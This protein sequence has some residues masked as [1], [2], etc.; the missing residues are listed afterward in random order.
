MSDITKIK[1]DNEREHS[2]KDFPA[3]REFKKRAEDDNP[4]GSGWP[5]DLPLPTSGGYGYTED[6]TVHKIDKKYLPED[7]RWPSD[8]PLPTA[9]GYGYTDTEYGSPVFNEDVTTTKQNPDDAYAK[10]T[11]VLDTVFMGGDTYKV[12][13]DGFNYYPVCRV[14]GPNRGIGNR[15]ISTTNVPDTGEP[16]YIER[17]RNGR[18]TLYTKTAGTFNVTVYEPTKVDHKIDEKY[19]PASGGAMVVTVSTEDFETYEADKTFDEISSAVENG[20]VVRLVMPINGIYANLS[21]FKDTPYEQ[22]AIFTSIS[23]SISSGEVLT[24]FQIDGDDSMIIS[25]HRIQVS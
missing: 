21:Q 23:G 1:I 10:A 14:Y 18:Q 19:L 7:C 8:L 13:F 12:V 16:F 3:N 25:T 15:S 11:V 9:G 20:T 6:E 5:S 4:G 2:Y 24:Q 22:I 17:D